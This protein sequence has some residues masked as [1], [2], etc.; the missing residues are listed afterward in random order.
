MRRGTW[1]QPGRWIAEK[2]F[3]SQFG[4]AQQGRVLT[5]RGRH[6]VDELPGSA[7]REFV[8]LDS[9]A[10]RHEWEQPREAAAEHDPLGI[11]HVD[12][13]C[14]PEAQPAAQIVERRRRL[15]AAAACFVEDGLHLAAAAPALMS[16]TD[17]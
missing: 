7:E 11:E 8:E 12:E 6:Y 17:E 9:H 15:G 4:C 13:A 1:P 5:K 14:Q 2:G 3:K 16:G 10:R